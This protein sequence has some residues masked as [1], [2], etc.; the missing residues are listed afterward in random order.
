M[1]DN[2][3]RQNEIIREQRERFQA[4][5]DVDPFIVR[6]IILASWRRCRKYGVGAVLNP[7]DPVL[8][9]AFEE[10][11]R[12]NRD[13]MESAAN[14]MNELVPSINEA[15]SIIGLADAEGLILHS[16][17]Q[18]SSQGLL[19]QF[20]K[21]HLATEEI[22]GT[23]AY[24]L[25]LVEK[26]PVEV[27]GYEHYSPLSQH[28]C[29]SA[30]PITYADGAVA[31]VLF[32]AT[33]AAS[34]HQHT[35]GMVRAAAQAVSEQL[36]LRKLLQEQEVMLELIDEGVIVL[37]AQDR[38]TSLNRKAASLLQLGASCTGRPIRDV[39]KSSAALDTALGTRKRL[40]D[41]ETMLRLASGGQAHCALSSAP[42]EESRGI[43]LTL[44]ETKRMREY[45][46]RTMGAKSV[47]TFE[48]I[49]GSSA[50]LSEVVDLARLAAQS[51]ITTLILG[52]SGTGKE[53]FAQAIHNAGAR[54]NGPFVAVNCG[55]LPRSL[56]E[57]ELF[58][59]AEGA[60][61]GARRLGKPGKFELADGGTIFLDEIGEMP[62]D[63]QVSMLRL[64]QEGELTRLGG[65]NVI[66]VNIKVIAATNKDLEQEVLG[67]SFRQDL[68]YRL[69][70]FTL[71]IPPLRRRR[72][73]IG[74][75]AEHF[76]AKF[77]KSL[78]KAVS[79]FAPEALDALALYNWPGN[80]RE[81]ENVVERAI[82][83]TSGAE[84]STQALPPAVLLGGMAEC[85]QNGAPKGCETLRGKEQEIIVDALR[86][87]K[88]NMRATAQRLGIARSALYKKI[89][90]FG[91]SPDDWRGKQ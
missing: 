5:L 37:D 13:L 30:A 6:R 71:N 32:V 17:G 67:R 75:L 20:K 25:C 65:N 18:E 46:V 27:L 39:V 56:V 41:Q 45:T 61:S 15:H 62:L 33:G 78:G 36:H 89:Q 38:I 81:L 47:Y 52:E 69:N 9:S 26:M 10:A 54:Q 63:A 24:G 28:W 90:R 80:V 34:Y 29:A 50:A 42:I 77:S 84:V 85:V 40:N 12:K 16:V 55:A 35:L 48:D 21:G 68:Y 73:D 3:A 49:I 11:A 87:N 44:R 88:G 2:I 70:V 51:D 53:L 23:N 82:N 59:Y 66:K 19:S 7:S 58:G 72:E 8:Q 43:V 86:E 57:S 31:G 91:I 1:M 14:V 76:R 74:I 60:F 64:L 4:G 83:I 79:A 22:A